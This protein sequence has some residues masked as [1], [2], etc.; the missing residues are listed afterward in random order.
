M[1][2]QNC[3]RTPSRI[4]C[5]APNL[6]KCLILYKDFQK[7]EPPWLMPEKISLASTYLAEM[8]CAQVELSPWN[9]FQIHFIMRVVF[10]FLELIYPYHHTP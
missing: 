6:K 7:G 3:V 2:N 4:W 8:I 9:S 1:S 10:I 5:L